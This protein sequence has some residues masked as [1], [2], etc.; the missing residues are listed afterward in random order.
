MENTF[1]Y[2][3]YGTSII[4]NVPLPGYDIHLGKKY[5]GDEIKLSWN[6]SLPGIIPSKEEL[7]GS[8]G[9]IE[10]YQIQQGKLLCAPDISIIVTRNRIEIF[11][12][13]ERIR[14]ALLICVNRGERAES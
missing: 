9:Y 10:C 14:E 6:Q 5:T 13:S 1:L 11:A 7:V 12:T 3:L 2:D 4:A 8:N